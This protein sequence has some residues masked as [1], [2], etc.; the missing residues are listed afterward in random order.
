M[1][2]GGEG[3]LGESR[4]L[5]VEGGAV[6]ATVGVVKLEAAGRG[7]CDDE[8]PGVGGAVVGA[9]EAK[10]KVGIESKTATEARNTVFRFIED[11]SPTELKINSIYYN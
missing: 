6:G 10:E 1:G 9:A 7:A 11:M 4:A 5:G 3:L 8:A 2:E